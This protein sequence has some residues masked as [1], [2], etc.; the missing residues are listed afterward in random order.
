MEGREVGPRVVRGRLVVAA[1][2]PIRN[3]VL[4]ALLPAVALLCGDGSVA[5]AQSA[6]ADARPPVSLTAAESTRTVTDVFVGRNVV[7][8]YVLSWRGIVAGSESVSRSG[9]PLKSG[10]D[11]R[12]DP[13]TG[14]MTFTAPL[15]SQQIVRVDYRYD[16]T[17]A[18]ANGAG[19]LAPMQFNLFERGNGSMSFDA[20]FRPSAAGSG[21]AAGGATS[22]GLM[23][24]G[25][26]GNAK[27]AA[28]SSLTSK[29]FLD[30]SGGNVL[31]RSGLQIQEKSKTSFGQVSA[32]F[33]RGGSRYAAAQET[34]IAAAR[35]ILESQVSLN[36]IHGIAASASFNQTSDLP[37]QG[38]GTTITTFGQKL[39]T[40]LGASTRLLASRTDVTTDSPDGTSVSRLTNHFQL[41]QQLGKT[42]RASAILDHVA[43]DA[44]D[45]QSVL[46]TSSVMIR[47]QPV[48]Q[49]TLTGT[50][51]NQIATTGATDTTNFRVEATPTSQVKL[52]ALISERYNHSSALHQREA[53]MEYAP[54][55]SI[56]LS[57]MLNMRAEAGAESVTRGI[58]AT[59]RP[60]QLVEVGGGFRF[61][62]ASTNGVPDQ[63][64]PDSYDVR[65]SVGLPKNFLKLT[66]GYAANPE[67]EHGTVARA[68]KS[69]LTLQS[70]LGQFNLT[71]GYQRQ[72]EY[73]ASRISSILDLSFGWRITRSTQI[74][75]SY[76]EAQTQD[77]GL[78]SADTY[79]LSLTHK[80]GS[81][82]DLSLSGAMT[83]QQKDGM[84]LPDPDYRADVKLGVKF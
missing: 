28:Q 73:L 71:G 38:K 72:D 43:T 68:Y 21:P 30:A 14:A 57:G 29:L 22:A 67:D 52:S 66:G 56:S 26:N 55:K 46:Q 77:Q 41:D 1:S 24:L 2:I 45:S 53:T 12:L 42:T 7:G 36:P 60:L 79:S 50:F 17:V 10:A 27:L 47:T 48:E 20:L 8:P 4:P 83:Q 40:S 25:F 61:R 74:V 19:M 23:L 34:G 37:E 70:T 84:L 58:A 82:F 69:Q 62:D 32:G 65:L 5:R 39:S 35:Q 16:P 31:D 63:D 3:R 80:I 9:Q 49:L 76:R 64:T 54:T 59:A 33:T 13:K 75:T 44:G 78:L 6:G 81:L 11:Y 51:G 15:K 18:V